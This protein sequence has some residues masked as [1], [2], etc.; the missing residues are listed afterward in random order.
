MPILPI[1]HI[2]TKPESGVPRI[3]GTRMTIPILI[4]TIQNNPDRSVT[5][6]AEDFGLTEA[7]IYAGLSYYHDH[8]E[9]IERIW[10]EG[11]AYAE[12]HGTSSAELRERIEAR[13]NGTT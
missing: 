3:R 13:R 4:A 5:Q 12:K 11:D 10:R 2:D 6:M 9:E 8:K 7:Q 1:E